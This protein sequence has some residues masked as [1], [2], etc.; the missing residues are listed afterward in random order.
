MSLTL[1]PAALSQIDRDSFEIL[2]Q[3]AFETATFAL[4]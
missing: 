1:D 2:H 3:G 4:G